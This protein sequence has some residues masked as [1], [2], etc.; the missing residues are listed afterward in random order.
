MLHVYYMKAMPAISKE[1]HNMHTIG[2][3]AST[4]RAA[5]QRSARA[6]APT[7]FASHLILGVPSTPFHNNC[8]AK[9]FFLA[10][11]FAHELVLAKALERLIQPGDCNL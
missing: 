1:K 9:L 10:D 2:M 5:C 4:M 11:H 6:R 3:Y 7:E 8:F